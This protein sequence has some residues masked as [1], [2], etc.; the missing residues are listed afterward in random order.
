MINLHDESIMSSIELLEPKFKSRKQ[1]LEK[2]W[3]NWVFRMY[4][5]HSLSEYDDKCSALEYTL[6]GFTESLDAG[7]TPSMPED[8]SGILI[9]FNNRA[10]AK[11]SKQSRPELELVVEASFNTSNIF[12]QGDSNE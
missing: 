7:V 4:F 5:G 2:P 3:H 8:L 6:F 11:W 1:V 12:S 9:R 10:F